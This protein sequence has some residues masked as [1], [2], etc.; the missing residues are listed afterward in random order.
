MFVGVMQ[1][2]KCS[3]GRFLLQRQRSM[4]ESHGNQLNSTSWALMTARDRIGVG[5]A[6]DGEKTL[7]RG[8]N[9][10]ARPSSGW[11]KLWSHKNRL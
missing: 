10:Q 7:P 3:R 6:L 5:V 4:L 9:P 2:S 8:L 1:S 11:S